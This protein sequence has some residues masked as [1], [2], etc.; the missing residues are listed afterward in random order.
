MK[1]KG[2]TW[3]CLAVFLLVC[4]FAGA[5]DTKASGGIYGILVPDLTS[6]PFYNACFNGVVEGIKKF[7]PTASYVVYDCA[8]DPAKQLDQ[9]AQCIQQKVKAIIMIPNGSSAVLSGIKDAQKAGIPVC[10]LDTATT[11]KTYVASTIVSNNLMAGEI[12]G[13][14]MVRSLPN[15]GNVVIICTPG[16]EVINQRLKG[17]YSKIAG[18]R[19]KV[20]QELIVNNGTTE[21]ALT[22]MENALSS[23]PN[24]KGVYTTGDTFAIGIAAALS[25]NGYK[26]GEIVVCSTDGTAKGVELVKEGWVYSTAAQQASKLGY[27]S[28]QAAVKILKGETVE[29]YVQLECLDITKENAASYS[30]F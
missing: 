15:G 11:D 1:E 18:T 26:P 10:V 16:N 2:K 9:I 8:W 24:L 7:D 13:E 29:K 6:S 12:S 23:I 4:S 17:F 25:A 28:V 5:V 20:V 30:A 22:L 27:E 14:A 3:V 21:E 19:I